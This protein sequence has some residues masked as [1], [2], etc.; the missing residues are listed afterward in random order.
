MNK[1][2]VLFFSTICFVT[3]QAQDFYSTL[4][5]QEN[6]TRERAS[7]S[8]ND[9]N[10]FIGEVE[11]FDSI[12]SSSLL[13]VF[14]IISDG[15]L[16]LEKNIGVDRIGFENVI[17][18]NNQLIL[19]G[20]KDSSIWVKVYDQ[21]FNVL[22][23]NEIIADVGGSSFFSHKLISYNGFYY[24]I[25]HSNVFQEQEV[26][27]IFKINESDLSLSNTRLV[28]TNSNDLNM[29]DLQVI[30]QDSLMLMYSYQPDDDLLFDQ[31]HRF[32]MLDENLVIFDSLDTE[33]SSGFSFGSFEIIENGNIAIKTPFDL[34]G[35]NKEGNVIW[36]YDLE[37][38]FSEIG[39]FSINAIDLIK[40]TNGD[41]LLCGN[42]SVLPTGNSDKVSGFA[43]KVS[44]AGEILWSRVYTEVVNNQEIVSTLGSILSLDDGIL[45]TGHT[46]LFK[47]AGEGNHGW[48]LKTDLD[49]CVQDDCGLEQVLSV[50]DIRPID[51]KSLFV[52]SSNPIRSEIKIEMLEDDLNIL[53]IDNS[54]KV[55]GEYSSL[56]R[57]PY[58]IAHNHTAG[59]YN[60]IVTDRKNRRQ[61]EK[62][63]VID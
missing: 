8:M 6:D 36:E 12:G 39:A 9:K 53:L 30:G 2:L 32:Y 29:L 7:F 60:L 61:V 57:G 23:S 25:G 1:T 62:V 15:T 31:Y 14:E 11:V 54:G 10:Y 50:D 17:V 63:L 42:L 35:I 26:G 56:N 51:V 40:E 59:L 43:M 34:Q 45:F 3:L 52:L 58:S 49:G 47:I 21:T 18:E 41:L 28:R 20:Y 38:E 48:V 24:I 46:G 16:V 55:V 5:L 22:M 19:S 4:S 13:Q 44:S 33:S 37:Q 27:Q